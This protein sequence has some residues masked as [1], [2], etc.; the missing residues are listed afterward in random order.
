MEFS[1]RLAKIMKLRGL[2]TDNVKEV[3]EIVQQ[4][5]KNIVKPACSK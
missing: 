5:F 2:G 4:L 1:R 3:R